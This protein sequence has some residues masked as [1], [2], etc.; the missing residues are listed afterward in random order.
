[1]GDFRKLKAWQ[2]AH[3]LTLAVYSATGR[4]PREEMYG[5]TSQTR[6]SCT[7]IPANIAEGCGRN[8]D[9]ELARFLRIALGSVSELEYYLLLARDLG[10]LSASD[11]DSLLGEATEVERMLAALIQT[12]KTQRQQPVASGS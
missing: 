4:F 1:M 8:G 7:S 2:K 11:Y 12:L 9:N 6:R 5:L 3:H 10:F